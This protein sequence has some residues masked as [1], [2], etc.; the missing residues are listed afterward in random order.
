MNEDNVYVAAE[1]GWKNF[2]HFA[3]EIMRRYYAPFRLDIKDT[4]WSHDGGRDGDA[5]YIFAPAGADGCA[6]DLGI[7]VRLWVEVKLRRDT[8]VS[9]HDTCSHLIRAENQKVNKLVF[10]TNGRFAPETRAEI[11]LFCMNRH[12]SCAFI[13]GARLEELRVN[14]STPAP[15]SN[16][17]VPSQPCP[18]SLDVLVRLS[19][20]PW[21]R[22][23]HPRGQV[24]CKPEVPVFLVLD[25]AV[26]GDLAMLPP[27]DIVLPAAVE[28]YAPYQ[29]SLS[30]PLIDG[31]RFR[32]VYAVWGR[33]GATF[34]PADFGI[35]FQGIPDQAPSLQLDTGRVTVG[36]R[37]LSPRTLASQD[38]VTAPLRKALDN[39]QAVPHHAIYAIEA[40][41]GVGKSYVVQ[42]LRRLWLEKRIREIW[43]DGGC[44]S[45]AWSVVATV[46]SA[47]FP[48]AA[49]GSFAHGRELLECWLTDAGVGDADVVKAIADR[50]TGNAS[51]VT[52]NW[53]ICVD[54]L[55]SLLRHASTHNPLVLVYEDLHKAAPSTILMIRALLGRIGHEGAG[56]SFILLTTRPPDH[57]WLES[58]SGALDS[59][60][61]PSNFGAPLD[62]LLTHL[63][64]DGK[65]LKMSRPTAAQARALLASSLPSAETG[66]LDLM[67]DQVG[68]TPFALKEL[69]AYLLA[70]E[71]LE[72]VG[73]DSWDLVSSRLPSQRPEL[74]G[75]RNATKE[76]LNLLLRKW[77]V[78][79][80]WL[81]DFLLAGALVGRDFQITQA[82]KAADAPVERL[83]STI[84]DLLFYADIAQPVPLNVKGEQLRFTHDLIRGAFLDGHSWAVSMR[85]AA[86]LLQGASSDM[87]PLL[88][89]RL[90]RNAGDVDGCRKMA[91]KGY[92][93][94]RRNALPWEALQFRLLSLWAID[95]ARASQFLDESRLVR[96]ITIDPAL[97]I[98]PTEMHAA[99]SRAE[100]ITVLFD[101]LDSLVNIGFGGG[102]VVDSL[103]TEATMLV[104]SVGTAEQRARLDYYA[105]RFALDAD[106]F[107]RSRE[108]H[109]AAEA[110]YAAFDA[111]G[112]LGDRRDNL[113]RLFLCQRQLD[114]IEEAKTT[115]DLLEGLAPVDSPEYSARM[116]AYRGY[117]HLYHNLHLVPDYWRQAAE[118][119]R[120]AGN[121][122][123]FAHHAIGR[124]YALLLLNHVSEAT[125]AFEEI[126]A[127]M[128]NGSK[129]RGI[130]LR[131]DLDLG[132]LA[133]VRQ[134]WHEAD[135]RL[136]DALNKGL[137]LDVFRKLWRIEANLA[138][139]YEVTGDME[140]CASYDRRTIHGVLVRAKAEESL[141]AKAHWLH[142]RHV[143]PVLNLMLRVRSGAQGS[144]ILLEKFSPAQQAEI[145]RLA[146]LVQ[147]GRLNKMPN[148]LRWHCKSIAGLNRFILTE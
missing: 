109:A 23:L 113:N 19:N 21:P 58:Q 26:K 132:A 29:S 28:F 131:L 139:L 136:S 144:Q 141:G 103:L 147:K 133:L 52:P 36:T 54:I 24:C 118:I 71:A 14:T 31:E 73:E 15:I 51:A 128:M 114:M 67:I 35:T 55:S 105:G 86:R 112:L 148:G 138:T 62:Q 66:L 65:L 5:V 56:N 78:S 3:R 43:L 97:E 104:R 39:W 4:P 72:P 27:P 7:I 2:E 70:T 106:D 8:A 102:K 87:P 1:K 32:V 57:V 84:L 93:Q 127:I 59:Q 88:R 38:S 116:L 33:A 45:D 41:A 135:A 81:R 79:Y 122:E 111:P 134:D 77:Q 64:Q 91:E 143:L 13:D 101:C 6:E 34:E 140:R 10:V 137:Q 68:T 120:A 117:L 85:L 82:S 108:R 95:P 46:F 53:G 12:I 83:P 9:L 142:Q 130:S 18:G 110:V 11:D 80:P 63:G 61:E 145:N 129:L 100:I 16:D 75:F 94:A 92:V 49:L 20:D 146:N 74:D 119:A 47:L 98:G 89:C 96:F 48:L 107:H 25:V 99:P 125:D 44:Q 124:A 126:K 69:M 37:F 115:L 42:Q 40:P 30:L 60:A 22:D 76:R 123:R 90:A 121:H 50:L 17:T